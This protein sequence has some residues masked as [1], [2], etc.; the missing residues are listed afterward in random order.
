MFIIKDD[1]LCATITKKGPVLV[2]EHNHNSEE[3]YNFETVAILKKD[4]V[5]F[6]FDC[7]SNLNINNILKK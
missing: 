1:D 2:I 3:L 4:Q 7:Y 5:P 6:D